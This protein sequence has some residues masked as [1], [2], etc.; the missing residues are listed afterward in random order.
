MAVLRKNIPLQPLQY[1]DAVGENKDDMLTQAA[2]QIANSLQ[3]LIQPIEH[4]IASNSATENFSAKQL[5]KAQIEAEHQLAASPIAS[6]LQDENITDILINNHSEI[7]VNRD[8][9]LEKTEVS[10]PDAESLLNL[11]E[12]IAAS[13]GRHIDPERPMVDARLSD[14]SRVNIIAPPMAINGVAISIRKFPKQEITLQSM[15]QNGAVS[16]Q[17]A[18]FLRLCAECRVSMLV[19]GGTGTG[20]TTMLNAISQYIPNDER[21]IT[22]EDTAELRLQQPHIVKLETKLPHIY[23]DRRSEVNATD[24]VRNALRMRPDRIIVGEVRG[25]EVFDMIQAMNSGHEGSM[26]TLHANSPRDAM[27]RLENL[28]SP[29]MHNTP[30]A[31][32]RR[33]IVSAINLIIQLGYG[34]DGMRKVTSITELVGMEGDVPTMQEIF[35]LHKDAQNETHQWT[36]IVPRHAK[37]SERAKAEGVFPHMENASGAR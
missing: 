13:V 7:F 30:V 25:E 15:V 6:L 24:L 14:G 31:N 36:A 18:D 11:A 33:Q 26:S 32:I 28:L 9:K 20:K 1:S 4:Y 17:M 3:N 22:I 5:Y 8:G 21:I 37:L 34:K 16:Q 27:T 2:V 35:T 23:G 10:F 12:S 29:V 19:T